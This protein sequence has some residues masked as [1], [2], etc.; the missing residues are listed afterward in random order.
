MNDTHHLLEESDTLDPALRAI[1]VELLDLQV[2]IDHWII[3]AEG[4]QP[5]NVMQFFIHKESW[6]TILHD[7]AQKVSQ[8]DSE[9]QQQ[10]MN[11]LAAAYYHLG[12]A[13]S[14]TEMWHY[15]YVLLREGM[16]FAKKAGDP[17][18]LFKYTE[19]MKYYSHAPRMTD[20][21]K[22]CQ[23]VAELDAL[24]KAESDMDSTASKN[25]KSD[26]SKNVVAKAPKHTGVAT[27]TDTKSV[28]T[29]TG[30]DHGC[31][32]TII[33]VIIFIVMLGLL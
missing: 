9:N 23:T 30:K 12:T 11:Y 7:A 13:C 32:W 19:E 10:G 1:E 3:Q 14:W 25:T 20:Q 26:D 33:G 8:L 31:F 21:I 29:G 6:M 4:Y 22:A 27:H 28:H 24:L 2:D 18:N 17:K 15:A 16:P 5:K